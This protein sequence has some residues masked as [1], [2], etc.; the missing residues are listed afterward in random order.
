[1]NSV[2]NKIMIPVLL[3]AVIAFATS[4]LSI[5]NADSISKKGDDIAN[6]YLVTI[7]N[8][9]YLS[10][11][12]QKL[13]RSA[14][15]Y[16]VA[17]GDAAKKSVKDNIESLKSE[18][19]GYMKDYEQTLDE[20]E[21]TAYSSYKN[22]YSQFLT[23]FGVLEKY[24]DT[25]QTVNA[26]KLANNNLVDVCNSLES[27]LDDMTNSEVEATDHAMRQMHA[28]AAFAKTTGGVCLVVAIGALIVAFLISTRKVVNPIVKTNKELKEISALIND[29]NGDLTK[30]VNVKSSDEIGQLAQGINQ[31]LDILQNTIG[32]IVEGS[33]NLDNMINSV[34][35]NVT[36]S[37][38]NAQDVSSAM[39]ELSATMQ[40]IAATI[41]TVNDNTESVG[42]NVVDI[43]DKTG[44][45]NN[46]SQDM[47]ERADSLAKSADENKRTTDEMVGNIVGTLKKAIEDSKSVERVNELTGEILNISSQTNLLALNASIEA[48]RAGEAGKGFAVVADEIRQLADSSRDTAN[49]IQAINEHVTS[50]VYQLIDNSNKIIKYIEETILADYDSFVQA[51]AQYNED[52][53]YISETMQ[54]FAEKTEK[55][56]EL[57]K[58]TVESI[59]GISSGVEQSANAVT[60]SAVSTSQLVE[61]MNSIDKEMSESRNTVGE[62]KAQTDV[63]KNF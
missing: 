32:K 22:Y 57:M 2:K 43:A 45:I 42:K 54:E 10:E 44:E 53:C 51:G 4:I 39:E 19:D 59:E 16:I 52:A 46:Y 20:N 1:M 50:A 35:E 7:E 33:K 31:F 56:K 38:D 14:Y 18:I 21:E 63:F 49:N 55:L 12:T 27:A 30:R 5:M 60:S 40:E 23:Q 11:S 48:A 41:Q 8:V 13:T 28:L 15:S 24:V 37:N 3:L 58:N 61:Q 34:G 6:N 36:V 29:N 9:G 62:L 17:E 47:R 26:S 25:N